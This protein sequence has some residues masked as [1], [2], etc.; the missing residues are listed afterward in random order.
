MCESVRVAVVGARLFYISFA[1]HFLHTHTDVATLPSRLIIR[2]PC[3]R[4]FMCECSF[5]NFILQF[6]LLSD[7]KKTS[8]LLR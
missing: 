6:Y 2:C 3:V 8:N 7:E 5:I 4:V 1:R